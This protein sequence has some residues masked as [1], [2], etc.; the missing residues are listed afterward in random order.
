[1]STAAYTPIGFLNDDV[2]F[3]HG[4][5]GRASY[6]VDVVRIEEDNI[7]AVEPN[8]PGERCY[9]ISDRHTLWDTRKDVNANISR[10][11]TN[12]PLIC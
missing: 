12:C 7:I 10:N 8:T 3:V 6:A 9:A 5:E 11:A 4:E 1:M 2:L